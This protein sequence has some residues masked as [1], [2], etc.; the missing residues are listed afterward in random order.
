M[1]FR[2][3]TYHPTIG[4]CFD[5]LFEYECK[6]NL[7]NNKNKGDILAIRKAI[8]AAYDFINDI[9]EPLLNT[10]AYKHLMKKWQAETEVDL[11]GRFES[12]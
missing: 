1:L 8:E 4:Y 6:K 9:V 3:L 10:T 5:E 2:S 7:L 11:I 12:K